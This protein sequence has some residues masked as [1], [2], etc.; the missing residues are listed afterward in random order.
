MF[1]DEADR[2]QTGGKKFFVYGAIFVHMNSVA[3][4]HDKIEK[5]RRQAGF[6]DTD[7]LKFATSTRPKAVSIEAHRELKR[8]VMLAKFNTF[9]IE[10]KTYGYAVLDRIPVEHPY[11]YLRQKF[12]V[13]M[14][15]PDRPSIR[16]GRILGFAHAVDGTSHLS[17]VAD[18]MLGAFRYC[19]N[20]PENE[21][22]GRQCSPCL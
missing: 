21:D 6:A 15:F 1:G 20:E 18:T 4:L 10:S 17:S 2:E 11:R 7:S 19:V 8:L 5:A 12:Q 22:A 14:T 16:L 3:V 13:G 9:L